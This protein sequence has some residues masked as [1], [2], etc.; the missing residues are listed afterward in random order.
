[1]FFD[2]RNLRERKG[3]SQ[4]EFAAALNEKWKETHPGDEKHFNVDMIIRMEKDPQKIALDVLGVIIQVFGVT[5]DQLL[6]PVIPRLKVPHV[7]NTWVRVEAIKHKLTIAINDFVNESRDPNQI[8]A[9]EQLN[10][11]SAV[12]MPKAKIA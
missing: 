11:L 7:N 10:A 5:F 9:V 4:A 8:S 1:M 12:A 6:N 3:F 2:L